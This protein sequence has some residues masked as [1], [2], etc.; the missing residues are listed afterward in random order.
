MRM[1]LT[2]RPHPS[3]SPFMPDTLAAAEIADRRR[4]HLRPEQRLL[5]AILEDAIH[6]Y[7][8][9]RTGSHDNARKL[10]AHTEAWL[11]SDDVSWP[12]SF[13]NVCAALGFDPQ[14]LR[15][16]LAKWRLKHGIQRTLPKPQHHAGDGSVTRGSRRV[17]ALPGVRV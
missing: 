5:Y 15:V 16:G 9:G 11:A 7:Q 8:T 12:M 17:T 4:P 10:L 1:P 13:Q 14:Y 3:G 6:V 2:G